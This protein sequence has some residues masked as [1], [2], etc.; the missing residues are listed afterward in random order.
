MPGNLWEEFDLSMQ[1]PLFDLYEFLT[2]ETFK[3]EPDDWEEQ[4]KKP[5]EQANTNMDK[6]P[7]EQRTEALKEGAMETSFGDIGDR[8]NHE[9]GTWDVPTAV[10]EL[11][12]SSSDDD[13]DWVDA[14]FNDSCRM[15]SASVASDFAIS[16]DEPTEPLQY[17]DDDFRGDD[18]MVMPGTQ[19]EGYDTPTSAPS[20]VM[21]R[22]PTPAEAVAEQRAMR[23][24]VR[25]PPTSTLA[26]LG[27]WR[28]L[29]CQI[30]YCPGICKCL[31]CGLMIRRIPLTRGRR[32]IRPEDRKGSK[33]NPDYRK[34]NL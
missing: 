5:D 25:P 10:P 22:R 2:S 8:A 9:I 7:E 1:D 30:E 31:D 19:G 3:S 13:E 12:V 14:V 21:R 27:R 26:V 28:C 11:A 18:D 23:Y 16:K 34:N 15:P 29:R 17:G 32:Q 24:R 4:L 20:F 33:L 6:K